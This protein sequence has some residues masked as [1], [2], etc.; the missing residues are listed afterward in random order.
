MNSNSNGQQEILRAKPH[1]FP[2]IF[3]PSAFFIAGVLSI[4]IFNGD[5]TCSACSGLL[6][7]IGFLSGVGSVPKY[8]KTEFILTPE[9]VLGTLNG[10]DINISIN[11]VNKVVIISN[12]LIEALG[13]CSIIIY[14]IGQ[15][16]TAFLNIGDASQI[17]AQSQKLFG[18][19]VE[20][21]S[22]RRN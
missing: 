16:E 15:Q 22:I 6:L 19:K 21:T 11:D 9:K 4:I 3:F 10:K 7:L 14:V 12:P 13:Y 17:I 5:P 20:I 8:R 1:W 18:S 2:H